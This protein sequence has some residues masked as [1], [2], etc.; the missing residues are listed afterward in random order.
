VDHLVT[1]SRLLVVRL[2][3]A[4]TIATGAA[5]TSSL[6]A[7]LVKY[8]MVLVGDPGNAPDTNGHGA[9]DHSYS[10]GRTEVTIGQYTTF[11][12]AVAASD[13]YELYAYPM[14]T[15]PESSGIQRSGEWGSYHYATIDNGGDGSRRPVTY[16][17]WWDAAR[18][19]NWM[20]N[21]QPTGAATSS[22]TENGAYDLGGWGSPWT[23]PARNAVNPNTG[24]APTYFVPTTDEWYKAA[25][26]SP[27]KHG[28]GDAGYWRYATQSDSEPGNQ[29]GSSANQANYRS[30][31]G[32]ATTPF[33]ER[34]GTQNYLTDV[35]SFSG[36]PSWYGTFDQSGNVGEWTDLDGVPNLYRGM[37]GGWWSDYPVHW[38]SSS[39]IEYHSGGHFNHIGFRLAGVA[40]VAVPEIAPAGFGGVM[41]VICG[42]LGLMER[43]RRLPPGAA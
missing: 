6:R 17:S 22:T 14:A 42:A 35:A 23:A 39:R 34:T 36:S 40:A 26:Y 10:I 24:S 20:S 33:A 27:D 31:T 28:V 29:I 21:G 2:L 19:A 7:D 4:F 16:V 9:V 37:D 13:P 5:S 18:F 11:L 25:Y 3:I 38:P 8:E 41:A 30:A 15:D 43:R 1:P 12:N 32:Y